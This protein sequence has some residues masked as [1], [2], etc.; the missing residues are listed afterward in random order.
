[1]CKGEKIKVCVV[2]HKHTHKHNA[3]AHAKTA[4]AA[5]GSELKCA[6]RIKVAAQ[7]QQ[8]QQETQA[9]LKVTL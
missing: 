9:A 6:N 2:A 7:Q 5:T 8:Q 1:M 4:H 3:L